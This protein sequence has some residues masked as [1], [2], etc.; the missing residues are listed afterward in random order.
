MPERSDSIDHVLF[1]VADQWRSD[2][3]GALGT[4]GVRTPNLDALAADGVLLAN[5]WCQASPCGPSRSSILTGTQVSTHGQWTNDHRADHGLVTLPAVLRGADVTPLLIGYTDT[6]QPGTAPGLEAEPMGEGSD[7]WVGLID[8]AFEVV[9]PFIWQHGFPTWRAELEARGYRL[10]DQ[11]PFGLYAP[12]G[13][14]DEAGLAPA[15]Y[16]AEDSD[17]AFL[18]DAAIDCLAELPPRALLHLNWLR[19]HPPMTAPRPYHRL[20]DPDEVAP[21]RRSLPLDRQAT[22]HPYFEQT[23]ADRSMTEYLQR[24]CTVDTVTERDDRHIRAAYY[25][26]CAEVDHQFG[27]IV[28]EL[29]STGR[30][31]STLI[32]FTSDHG[33]SLGDH[34]MY[35]RRGPFDGHFKVPCIIRDPRPTADRSR[36]TTVDDFTA[37]IDLLPTICDALGIAVPRSVEGRSLAGHLGG[38]PGQTWRRHVRYDMDWDDHL[39]SATRAAVGGSSLDRRFSAVRTEHHR[40]V[41]F[42][43]MAPMLFDLA[44]DPDETTDRSADPSL[45]STVAELQHLLGQPS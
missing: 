17:V 41:T 33:D 42:P 6:P 35:G 2:A 37:N 7:G 32:I 5:H 4:P 28:A 34:W 24:R 13:L 40:L 10:D 29:K 3:L 27:R 11:H 21:P 31:D 8:P 22:S 12:D 36:A 14:P 45:A 9:Q 18:T 38:G 16:E 20:V 15:H 19:P 25:G 44:E 23:V 39:R 30:Y 1:C 26:L 43:R